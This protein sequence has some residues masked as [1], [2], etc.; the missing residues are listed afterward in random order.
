MANPGTLRFCSKFDL[1]VLVCV[2][3]SRP[4]PPPT[5][6]PPPPTTHPHPPPPPKTTTPPPPPPRPPHPPPPPRTRIF[7]LRFLDFLPSSFRFPPCNC[8][9]Q[10]PQPRFSPPTRV[11]A[12]ISN[13]SE[14]PPLGVEYS[15]FC[16]PPLRDLIHP[17]PTEQ[18]FGAYPALFSR[19]SFDRHMFNS[20]H[21]VVALSIFLSLS[22]IR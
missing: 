20:K 6:H 11:V 2:R 9:L 22:A 15:L 1:A 13:S 12:F 19:F 21:E 5:P 10:L 18:F 17:L 8:P 4:P 7:S 14:L 3:D 16:G